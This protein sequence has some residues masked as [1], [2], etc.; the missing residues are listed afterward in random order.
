MRLD[1]SSLNVESFETAEPIGDIVVPDTGKGG[2]ESYCYICYPTGNTD[3]AC[4]PGYTIYYPCPLPD[5]YFAPC[6]RNPTP[7]VNCA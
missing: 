1:P 2:P 5:T 7:C 6:T 4:Q 3:P